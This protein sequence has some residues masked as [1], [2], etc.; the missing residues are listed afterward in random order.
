MRYSKSVDRLFD[1]VLY[2]EDGRRVGGVES[3]YLD[4]SS[5]RPAWVTVLF[6]LLGRHVTYVPLTGA[7]VEDQRI[8]VPFSKSQIRSAPRIV[9]RQHLYPN[10]ER[11]LLEHYSDDPRL[12][13]ATR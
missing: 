6:G 1:A 12:E 2:D 9:P 5:G 10:E 7:R 13:A 3:V 4:D 11:R 8:H